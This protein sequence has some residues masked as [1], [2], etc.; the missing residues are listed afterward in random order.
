MSERTTTYREDVDEIAEEIFDEHGEDEQN[1]HTPVHE[2][3]DGHT[4]IIYTAENEEVL[5]CT[6]NEPDA[7]EIASMC[8][9]DA[10]WQKMRTV[11]AYM[12]ME[13]D[14]FEKLNEL[15]T[16]HEYHIGPP[17][18]AE[19]MS[20]TVELSVKSSEW[21]D[22]DDLKTVL[23]DAIKKVLEDRGIMSDHINEALEEA[24]TCGSLEAKHVTFD[25][26]EVEED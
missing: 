26:V 4:R 8:G 13:R 21:I 15:K 5:R 20:F 22:P 16:E 12:A 11:A 24:T 10:D 6:N 3:V 14:V 1:W 19:D 25:S 7:A 23:A 18:D 17:S 2:T 9:E